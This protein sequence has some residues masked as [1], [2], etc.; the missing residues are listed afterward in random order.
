VPTRR[1]ATAFAR[2]ART[3]VSSVSM[4]NPRARPT[5]SRP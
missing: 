2:G 3:G 4:P 5:K 1:S